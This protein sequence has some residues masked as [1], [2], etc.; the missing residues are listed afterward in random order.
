MGAPQN[1]YAT[2]EWFMRAL[3]V[4]YL[5][6]SRG[7]CVFALMAKRERHR[8]QHWSPKTTNKFDASHCKPFSRAQES[9]YKVM[10]RVS[11]LFE[12]TNLQGYRRF[13]HRS[14]S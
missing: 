11:S 13:C 4:C 14:N 10:K 6:R 3:T 1:A 8:L 7:Q 2:S 9:R 12:A 5:V